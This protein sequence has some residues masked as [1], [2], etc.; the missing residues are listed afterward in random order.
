LPNNVGKEGGAKIKIKGEGFFDTLT[1]KLRLNSCIGERPLD[2]NW[3][4]LDK[5]FSFI[6]P[7]AVW[8]L[9]GNEPTPELLD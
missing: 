4:K 1:K 2:L 5:F 9:G 8:L 7:P 3:E 6:A